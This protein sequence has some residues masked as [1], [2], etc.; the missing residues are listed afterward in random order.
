MTSRYD[1]APNNWGDIWERYIDHGILPGGFGTALLTNNLKAAVAAA[2]W[3]NIDLI[4]KHIL[5]LW[6]HMPAQAWGTPDAVNAWVK[7]GGLKGRDH[8]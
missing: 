6:D 4:P 7:Q 2:D 5:W 8:E 1:D 3:I